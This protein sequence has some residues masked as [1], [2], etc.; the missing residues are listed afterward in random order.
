[1]ATAIIPFRPISR[2]ISKRRKMPQSGIDSCTGE[3]RRGDHIVVRRNM[4]PW[5]TS[6]ELGASEELTIESIRDCMA[7]PLTF[8][9]LVSNISN[10]IGQYLVTCYCPSSGS[11]RQIWLNDCRIETM[12]FGA[13]Q[14]EVPEELSPIVAFALSHVYAKNGGGWATMREQS[15]PC[16]ADRLRFIEN[17]S[18]AR[19]LVRPDQRDQ[20]L[21]QPNIELAK[22]V[23]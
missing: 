21:I 13:H 11:T 5:W 18:R 8:E 22:V 17:V 10:N 9:E 16:I 1:M 6:P 23:Q 2:P 7:A 14:V 4:A 20:L 19:G 3:V 15:G 12:I